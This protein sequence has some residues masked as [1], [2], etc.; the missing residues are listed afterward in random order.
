M[1]RTIISGKRVKKYQEDTIENKLDEP[2]IS[3]QRDNK[4]KEDK[5]ERYSQSRNLTFTKL[6]WI[7]DSTRLLSKY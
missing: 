6:F 7:R 2:L 3:L 4:T 1:N 5:Y